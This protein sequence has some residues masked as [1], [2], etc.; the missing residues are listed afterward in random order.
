MSEDI[1]E[2]NIYQKI[3]AIRELVPYV[4][5][6]AT[7]QGYKAVTHD[8]VTKTI[9]D[10]LIKFGVIIVP[11]LMES[12]MV[13]TG[14]QTGNGVPWS[15]Y[16]AKYKIDFVN[17]DVPDEKISICVEGHGMDLG[18]KA[19][20]KAL[21]LATKNAILKLFAIE[22]GVNEEEREP[23]KAAE[24]TKDLAFAKQLLI[25]MWRHRRTIDAVRDAI[26]R[27]DI[28]S[29]A[30]AWYEL[31]NEEQM[32]LWVAPTKAE[33]MGIEP[34]FTIEDKKIIKSEEWHDTYY[35]KQMESIDE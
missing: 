30:E 7:V 11:S 21:S 10:H 28:E 14:T 29:G 19:P 24:D 34:P 13:S 18:D 6:T 35:S 5:K 27:D 31:T 15:R 17:V 4:Q 1:S 16:E 26:A 33:K 23:Q 2:M 8:E 22:T 9:R 3:N 32:S 25:N 12:K 20:G